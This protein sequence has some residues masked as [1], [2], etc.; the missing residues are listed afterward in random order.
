MSHSAMADIK[1]AERSSVEGIASDGKAV[2]QKGGTAADER[3]MSRM[4][5]KQ[6]LRVSRASMFVE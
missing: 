6:E 1:L 4:G 2:L 3:D 5:K